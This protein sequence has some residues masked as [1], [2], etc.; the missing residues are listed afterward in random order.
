MR[1]IQNASSKSEERAIPRWPLSLCAH[2]S[3]IQSSA[4]PGG[5]V[6]IC[7]TCFPTRASCRTPMRRSAGIVASDPLSSKARFSL[8]ASYP[9]SKT[10]AQFPSSHHRWENRRIPLTIVKRGQSSRVGNR[11]CLDAAVLLLGPC[12]LSIHVHGPRQAQIDCFSTTGS[13]YGAILTLLAGHLDFSNQELRISLK[14]YCRSWR[15]GEAGTLSTTI[16]RGSDH[17]PHF[18]AITLVMYRTDALC[19]SHWARGSLSVGLR[20]KMLRGAVPMLDPQRHTRLG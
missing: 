4:T 16:G 6:K 8:P 17:T 10:V 20:W 9:Q 1:Q 14:L 19:G 2:Q 11:G 12:P 7:K 5:T 15:L 3:C 13:Y 18:P